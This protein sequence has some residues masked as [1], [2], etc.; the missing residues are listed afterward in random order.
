LP[1]R[2][3]RA[4]WPLPTPAAQEPGRHTIELALLPAESAAALEPDR[5]IEDWEDVFL[6]VQA[7]FVRE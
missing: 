5:L 4:G 7:V 6:P 2:P 1:E 3:G